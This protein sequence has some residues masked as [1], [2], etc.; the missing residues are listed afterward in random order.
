MDAKSL[1]DKRKYLVDYFQSGLTYDIDNI[2]SLE[3]IVIPLYNMICNS[4]QYWRDYNLDEKTRFDI[5]KDIEWD[6]LSK[7]NDF[8]HSYALVQS[9]YEQLGIKIDFDRLAQN[10]SL[11]I[12]FYDENDSEN[13]GESKIDSFWGRFGFANSHLYLETVDH[14]L[15]LDSVIYAHEIGHYIHCTDNKSSTFERNLLTESVAFLF[16]LLFAD[17]LI[18]N[19]YE[20]EG[21]LEKRIILYNLYYDS[22]DALD[23]LRIFISFLKYGD[24][25]IEGNGKDFDKVVERCYKLVKNQHAFLRRISYSIAFSLSLYMYIQYKNNKEFMERIMRFNDS[26]KGNVQLLDILNIIGITNF[27]EKN[28]KK[29]ISAFNEFKTMLEDYLRKTKP[30]V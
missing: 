19:N 13:F 11:N 4:I 14:G 24:I 7:S 15:V 21:I 22:L 10:G 17:Y 8:S 25:K 20:F 26:M 9:F 1:E 2:A 16:E 29:I 28:M 12:I 5:G 18:E 23:L 30:K 3:V 6:K 27:D